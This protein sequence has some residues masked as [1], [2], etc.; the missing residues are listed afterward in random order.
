MEKT[1]HYGSPCQRSGNLAL[2]KKS[3][4]REAGIFAEGQW[5]LTRSISGESWDAQ[6]IEQHQAELG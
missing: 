6:A 2:L 5:L 3:L 4:N 1:L